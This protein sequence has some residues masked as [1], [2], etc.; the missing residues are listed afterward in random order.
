VPHP[1]H[2]HKHNFVALVG[3]RTIPTERPPLV[4]EYSAN[5]LQIQ[6][7]AWSARRI[8]AAVISVFLRGIT[9][10]EVLIDHA[11]EA[12]TGHFLDFT[13]KVT[14]TEPYTSTFTLLYENVR[15]Y[16]SDA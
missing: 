6:D 12:S 4:G 14:E 16:D 11:R 3:E 9:S 15:E 13:H 10:T 1:S 2:P 8:P 7:V 5:F